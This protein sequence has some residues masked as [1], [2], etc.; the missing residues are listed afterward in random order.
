[1]SHVSIVA[2]GIGVI[3]VITDF[4]IGPAAAFIVVADVSDK[5]FNLSTVEFKRIL[6]DSL[7]KNI[8]NN[9]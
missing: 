4:P 1:M 2:I 9:K 6:D 8:I 3:A 5:Y 7:Q